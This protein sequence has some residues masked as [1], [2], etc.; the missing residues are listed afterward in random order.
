MTDHLSE[1]I[2]SDNSRLIRNKFLHLHLFNE[3]KLEI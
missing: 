2:L 3:R 1:D